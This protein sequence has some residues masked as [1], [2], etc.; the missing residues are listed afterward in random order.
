MIGL[1]EKRKRERKRVSWIGVFPLSCWSSITI[2]Q[3][4]CLGTQ[5]V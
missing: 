4:I 3:R 5:K 1:L 2:F